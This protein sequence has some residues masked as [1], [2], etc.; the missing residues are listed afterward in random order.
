[1]KSYAVSMVIGSPRCFFWRK[2]RVVT[3][4]RAAGAGAGEVGLV[5]DTVPS[6]QG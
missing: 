4:L 3:F 6:F 2:V 1:M 5:V